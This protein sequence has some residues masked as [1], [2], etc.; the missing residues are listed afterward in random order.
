MNSLASPTRRLFTLKNAAGIVAG[1]AKNIG[2]AWAVAH[3]SASRGELPIAID[4]RHRVSAAKATSRSRWA[5]AIDQM[6]GWVRD[7][8]RDPATFGIEGRINAANPTPDTWR[9]DVEEWRSLDA[10][11]LDVNTMGGGLRGPQAHIDRLR[12]VK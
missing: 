1:E 10:N 6:R 11:Y 4:R 8:G 3:E 12:Q 9:A 2:D 7:G 5:F